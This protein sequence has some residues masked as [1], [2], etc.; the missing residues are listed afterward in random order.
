MISIDYYVDKNE[1]AENLKS[2]LD[3][4]ENLISEEDKNHDIYD[5]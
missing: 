5:S 3:E 2:E 4:L 1:E